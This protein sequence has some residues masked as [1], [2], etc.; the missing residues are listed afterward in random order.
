MDN[1]NIVSKIEGKGNVIKTSIQNI[2]EIALHL[3]R[4][5]QEIIKFFSYELGAQTSFTDNNAF[6]YGPHTPTVL[7]KLLSM[8]IETFVICKNCKSWDTRYNLKFEHIVS[9]NKCNHLSDTNKEHKLTVFIAK[10][11]N[12]ETRL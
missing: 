5:A 8:Y 10:H 9:C 7:Q 3:N 12:E 6:V 2:M 1:L 4:D 11:F